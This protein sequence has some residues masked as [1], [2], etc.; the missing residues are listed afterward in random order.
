M[1]FRLLA[2]LLLMVS[3]VCAQSFPST[4]IIDNFDRT[5]EDP[6]TGNWSN[7]IFN[8][9]FGCQIEGN[10]LSKATGNPGDGCWYNATT[11]GANQELYATW[12]NGTGH[13][14]PGAARM[15]VCLHNSPGTATAR[16]YGLRL[17]KV[18]AAPDILQL[19]S[20]DGESFSNIGTGVNQEFDNGDKAGIRISGDGTLY[21]Y[22]DDA[23]AGWT[24]LSTETDSTYT[25]QCANSYLGFYLSSNTFDL[26]DMG[27]GTVVTVSEE[28]NT[29]FMPL[30]FG[31]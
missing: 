11:Y 2:S 25:T 29:L 13:V 31:R 20:F 14:T 7:N 17:K 26:D 16:G 15:I 30:M 22:F 28:T 8:S 9:G 5:N 6:V 23:G 12:P 21:I 4:G 27:G 18:D 10:L 24:L 19:F 3:T 1:V